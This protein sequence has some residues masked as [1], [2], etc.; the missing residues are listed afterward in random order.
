[1]AVTFFSFME[2]DRH[3]VA[4]IKGR[5]VNSRYTNLNFKVKDLLVR[6]DTEDE[7]VIKQAITKAMYGTSRT[8]VFVGEYTHR[9][10]WVEHEIEMTIYKG[11]PV[12][13][14]WL[15]DQAGRTPR[16]LSKHGIR[17]YT[18]SE[19]RLQDLATR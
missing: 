12:Y 13:A 6:W 5:A 2:A 7:T 18:W 1:M 8:I 19:E 9:S 10:N 14:I 15:K 11:K 17:V 4:K 16:V 3:T